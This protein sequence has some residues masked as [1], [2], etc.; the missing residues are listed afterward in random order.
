MSTFETIPPYSEGTLE[1]LKAKFGELKAAELTD[2]EGNSF[3][4]ALVKKPSGMIIGEFE[5]F[6]DRNP[7]KAREILIKGCVVYGKDVVMKWPQN[8]EPYSAAFDACA[9]MIPVGK[10][11]LKNV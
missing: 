11:T 4:T 7:M 3:G 2:T 10:A 5:K 1:E 6:V 8:S 9:Q